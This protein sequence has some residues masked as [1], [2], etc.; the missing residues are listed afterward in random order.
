MYRV[1]ERTVTLCS[2][3]HLLL[4]QIWRYNYVLRRGSLF[5]VQQTTCFEILMINKYLDNS[6]GRVHSSDSSPLFPPCC[7]FH[8]RVR[9]IDLALVSSVQHR[10]TDKEDYFI[11]D[12]KTPGS[13]CIIVVIPVQI[14]LQA[15]TTLPTTVRFR[16][17]PSFRRMTPI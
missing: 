2:P 7:Q 15:T 16:C 10:K 9:L 14:K 11:K 3:C 17:W 13:A 6:Y 5:F 12:A 8:S 1:S 4:L